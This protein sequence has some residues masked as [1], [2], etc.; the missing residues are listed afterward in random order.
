MRWNETKRNVEVSERRKMEV[1]VE[2][3]GKASV[4][5]ERCSWIYI[6]A[7]EGCNRKEY[8]EMDA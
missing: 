1:S 4:I 8:T 6:D 2:L 7:D 5:T 3:L